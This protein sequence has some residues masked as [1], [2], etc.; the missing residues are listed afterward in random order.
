MLI[1]F[2]KT[3]LDKLNQAEMNKDSFFREKS[4]KE[5]LKELMYKGEYLI[6]PGANLHLIIYFL[7]IPRRCG[8]AYSLISLH[9]SVRRKKALAPKL[10]CVLKHE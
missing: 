1:F 2:L 5:N 6:S 4:R 9:I 7:L 10:M 8:S 3:C